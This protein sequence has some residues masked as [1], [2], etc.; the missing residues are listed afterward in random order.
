MRAGTL[1]PK[2][3]L[4]L[5]ME[6]G[7]STKPPIDRV[8]ALAFSPDGKILASGGGIPSR[9]GE[10]LLWNAADGSLLR[11]ISGAHSDTVF[12]LSF[13]PDGSMLASAGADKF[14]RVFDMKTGKLVKSFE[15]HTN[16]VL[17][18]A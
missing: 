12:D 5:V 6:P 17:G 16:H 2:W 13:T 15:G 7:E 11:E 3:K 9:D 18:V 4:Q 10:L 14:A 8:L 1:L